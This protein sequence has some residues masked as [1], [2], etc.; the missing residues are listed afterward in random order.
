MRAAKIILFFL[1]F[2]YASVSAQSNKLDSLF[3]SLREASSDT[4]RIN[5]LSEIA[6]NYLQLNDFDSTRLYADKIASISKNI[7]SD[8][9]KARAFEIYGM[10]NDNQSDF[11]EAIK[12]FKLSLELYEK[13]RDTYRIA[14]LNQGIA[15]AYYSKGANDK[16]LKYYMESLKVREQR[17]DSS[18]VASSYMGISN[19]YSMMHRYDL[20][21]KYAK[22][23]L[24]LKEKYKETK[25]VSWLLNNVGS[26]YLESGDTVSAVPYFLRSI[27]IKKELNDNYGLATTY[28]NIAMIH[29]KRREFARS[30]EYYRLAMNMRYAINPDDDYEMSTCLD[31]IGSVYMEMGNYDSAQYYVGK[32]ISLGEKVKSYE[33]LRLPYYNMAQL[34]NKK[35]RYQEAFDFMMKH[36]I[37][38]DSTLSSETNQL[39]HE[40]AAKYDNEKKEREIA[41]QKLEISDQKKSKMLFIAIAGFAVILTVVVLRGYLNKKK[42]NFLLEEKNTLIELQKAIVEEKNKDITDSIHYAQ[43]IQKAILPSREHLQR[44][45]PSSFILFKPKDIVSGDFYWIEQWGDKTIVAVIDCTGHGVPGAFMT[46]VAYSLLN[47]AVLEHGIDNPAAILNEMRRNLNKML[48]QK[49]DSEALKDGM[50]ISIYAIDFKKMELEYAGAYNPL[51]YIR[52]NVLTEIKADKQPIGVF[53]DDPKP[54]TNHILKLEKGDSLYLFTDGYADQF[55]GDKGKKFKYKS[56]QELLISIHEKT[57]EEQKHELDNT[58]ESWKGNLQQ[59]DD[60][61]IFGAR[62]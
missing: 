38:K 36:L 26:C 11:D 10:I 23:A 20:A 55:G 45:L 32:A 27:E 31:D 41:M 57:G 14:I 5:I 35:G 15:N 54:F 33:L 61:C 24:R 12:N 42:A 58:F 7:S 29:M 34:L 60:V 43:R 44:M 51:W 30:L 1:L 16:A 13:E 25:V 48:R 28:K 22:E 47:E 62:V 6:G 40:M 53:L 39:M 50:D 52:K 37:A 19:V 46:F 8:K 2:L 17:G 9:G 49:N 56:L 3:H 59:L 18:G 4:S 21:I